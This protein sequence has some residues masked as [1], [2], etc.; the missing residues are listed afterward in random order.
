MIPEKYRILMNNE[1]DGA[2]TPAEVDELEIYLRQHPAAREYLEQLKGSLANLKDLEDVEPPANLTGRILRSVARLE[3]NS[4][5]SWQEVVFGRLRMGYAFS[6]VI[7]VMV[8]FLM[9]VVIPVDS[10]GR[11]LNP[12]DLFQGTS[13][14]ELAGEWVPAVPLDL[15]D[16]L[17]QVQ[18]YL[19]EDKIL[20]RF[21]L[22]TPTDL[23][24]SFLFDEK[25]RLQGI[26]YAENDNFITTTAQGTFELSGTGTC[27][28]DFLLSGVSPP[29][30]DLVLDTGQG[31][32]SLFRQKITW[33]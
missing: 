21:T 27:R 5:V 28:C 1:I 29:R 19:L 17:G 11:N 10:M 22:Q 15:V 32:D 30:L 24:L 13:T 33:P 14:L 3:R 9:H 2:N 4:R 18:S 7:G 6:A 31:Q 16:G 25:A 12:V 20:V 8:G 26:Q 23:K